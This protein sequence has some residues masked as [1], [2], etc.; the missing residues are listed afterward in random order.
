[1]KL[2]KAII[3]KKSLSLYILFSIHFLLFNGCL[4]EYYNNK[5]SQFG[6]Y[7]T[8]LSFIISNITVFGISWIIIKV[9]SSLFVFLQYDKSE[10]VNDGRLFE[11]KKDVECQ[12][13]NYGYNLPENINVYLIHDSSYNARAIGEK[14]IVVN[15]QCLE[16]DDEI[17]RAIFAH[18]FAHILNMDSSICL[19]LY[20][21]NSIVTLS[22]TISRVISKIMLLFEEYPLISLVGGIA[23]WLCNLYIKFWNKVCFWVEDIIRKQ[24][25]YNAD[26]LA[27]VVGNLNGMVK[28]LTFLRDNFPQTDV[29]TMT[30]PSLS[31]RLELIENVCSKLDKR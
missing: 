26:R 25:E 7:R 20:G 28:L 11:L 30:H 31:S 6:L 14:N 2:L 17:I 5:Y 16:F 15:D 13:K 9:H 1:M 22:L 4:L 12:Y 29:D 21:Y 24:S 8:I 23:Y 10:K 3:A 18:E 27:C 19:L